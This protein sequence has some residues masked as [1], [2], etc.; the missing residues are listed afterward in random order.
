MQAL[1]LL[2]CHGKEAAVA[3][4]MRTAGFAVF[5]VSGFNTDA[6]GTFT[7]EVPRQGSMLDAAVRKARLASELGGCRFGLGSEGSFGGD[8]W[9]GIS[10]W[11]RELIVWYDAEQNRDVAAFVQGPET[12]FA[13]RTVASLDEALEFADDV[14]F[15]E[16][17]VIVGQP[18]ETAFEKDFGDLHDLREH[19]HKVLQS[20]PV[21]LSTD[22]RAH[23]NPTRMAMIRRCGEELAKRLA[24][25]CPECGVIGFGAVAAVPGAVCTGCS[26]PTRHTRAELLRCDVCHYQVERPVRAAVPPERCEHCNP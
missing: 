22:M 1:A 3:G 24:T 8:P 26:L 19:L 2:T 18:G 21:E 14:G 7:G 12:N 5:T 20:G 6:L 16:H 4:P 11:A 23:R 25:P 15:P 17:G 13:R 10:G 9:L